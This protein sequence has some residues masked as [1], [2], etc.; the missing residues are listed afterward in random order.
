MKEEKK[1]S[2]HI[3]HSRSPYL[4]H[5]NV[6]GIRITATNQSIHALIHEFPLLPLRLSENGRMIHAT[7]VATDSAIR[8]QQTILGRISV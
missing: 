5:S 3:S 2:T 7:T 8:A 6:D 4:V 1:R